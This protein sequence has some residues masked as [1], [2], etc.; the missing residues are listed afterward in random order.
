[1]F[2]AQQIIE[3]CQNTSTWAHPAPSVCGCKGSGW[4]LSEVDTW[5][6]CP[7]HGAGVPHPEDEHGEA[8]KAAWDAQA[9]GNYTWMRNEARELGFTGNFR[10]ACEKVVSEARTPHAWLE[11]AREVVEAAE[12][13]TF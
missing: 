3:S 8:D 7:Y 5:H 6:Q 12:D 10:E 11:A 9:R 4:F 2:S 1:M 13:A